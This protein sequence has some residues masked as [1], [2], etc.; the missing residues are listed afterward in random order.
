MAQE[1]WDVVVKLLNGPL[2]AMGEQVLRGP[3]VRIGARPGPGGFTLTGYRGLDARQCTITAY[4]DGRAEVAPVGGNQVRMAPHANVRWQDLDPISGPEHLSR[5]CVIHLGP[6]GRGATI[7]FVECRRLGVWRKGRL[8]SEVAGGPPGASE[9][10]PEAYDVRR[11]SLL[12][13]SVAPLWFMGCSFLIALT[14]AASLLLVGLAAHLVRPVATIGPTVEGYEM[15]ASV[16]VSEDDLAQEL[17]EGLE[18]PYMR[19][20]MEP[21]IEAAAARERGWE[22]PE[23]WDQRFFQHVTASVRRHASS[24]SFFRRLDAVRVE[25]AKVVLAL[26]QADLPEVFA[27]I[28][29]QESR[30]NASITSEVCAEGWWQFMPEVAYRL[31]REGLDFRVA[32]CSFQTDRKISWSPTEKA[33]PPRVRENGAYMSEGKCVIDACN[34]DDRKNLSRATAAAI[35]TLREAWSD[36]LLRGSGSA[37]QLTITSHNAGYD[38]GRFGSKYRKS[39]NVKPAY[40][41]WIT[42]NPGQGLHFTGQNIRC[43]DLTKRSACGGVYLAETQHYAYTI[44][45]QHFLAVCYYAQNYPEE[46]AF[47][48]WRF[49]VSSDGYCDQFDIPTREEVKRKVVK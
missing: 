49:F 28:P 27:G 36:P 42:K 9:P 7:E 23:A 15:W 5:G 43:P 12:R 6:V 46:Q 21:N 40:E 38:D 44:V 11:V 1:R 39:V 45:A 34:V 24:W 41:R 25:Y 29:Y 4:E 13:T 19:F 32:G 16:E 17:L 30:Y 10:V 48:P 22:E 2:S 31:E 18:Q 8:V 3:V 14:T 37:V 26:R 20:I 33:P 47:K 35:F